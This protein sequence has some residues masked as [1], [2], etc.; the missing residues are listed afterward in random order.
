M[1]SIFKY[2]LQILII[3]SVLMQLEKVNYSIQ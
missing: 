3:Q 2:A 1:R